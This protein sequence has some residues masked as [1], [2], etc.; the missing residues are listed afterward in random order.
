MTAAKSSRFFYG[1]VV[2]GVTAL[3]FGMLALM[4]AMN[5]VGTLGS[6]WLTGRL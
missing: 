4:G 5:F 3:A 2:V 6:G 1:W